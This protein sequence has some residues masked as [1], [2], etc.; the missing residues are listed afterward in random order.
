M[1][2]ASHVARAILLKQGE[3]PLSRMEL[4]SQLQRRSPDLAKFL[5]KLIIGG[6]RGLDS[7]ALRHGEA[8][9]RL[10][11]GLLQLELKGDSGASEVV[12][13]EKSKAR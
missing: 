13:E 7:V 9:L 3:F 1:F 8:L 11:I 6:G 2:A 5:S 12:N 10:E 4:P